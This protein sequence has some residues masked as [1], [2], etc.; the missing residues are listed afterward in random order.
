M[1]LVAPDMV[2]K[3]GGLSGLMN[4]FSQGVGFLQTGMKGKEAYTSLMGGGEASASSGGAA[5][6]GFS[7]GLP[8]MKSVFGSGGAEGAAAGGEASGSTAAGMTPYALPV[9][10]AVLTAKDIKETG[11]KNIGP[12]GQSPG[13]R[14]GQQDRTMNVIS[15]LKDPV[16]ATKTNLSNLGKSVG[17]GL[18]ETQPDKMS[19]MERRYDNYGNASKAI[20]DAQSALKDANLSTADRRSIYRKLEQARTRGA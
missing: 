14:Q 19:A 1:A 17:L 13:E 5:G 7:L 16:G 12:I 9:A 6:D 2:Q 18:T 3:K 11:G 15:G 20:A 10:A 4:M 8:A